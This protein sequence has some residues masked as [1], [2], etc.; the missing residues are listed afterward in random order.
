MDSRRTLPVALAVVLLAALGAPAA[1]AAPATIEGKLSKRGFTVM[2][3][4]ARGR[5][6]T[7]TGARAFRVV[8][9][10]RAVT[11]HLRDK[12]GRYAGP[13]VVGVD[14]KQVVVGVRAGTKL[15]RVRVRRGYATARARP[16]DRVA[17]LKARARR[18]RPIGAGLLGRVRAAASGKDGAGRDPDRDGLPGAFDVDDDGDLVLDN[19]DRTPLGARTSVGGYGQFTATV[20]STQYNAQWAINGGLEVSYLADARG[21]TEGASGYAVNQNAAGPFA[22]DA[23]FAKLR[24]LFMIE[25]GALFLPLSEA[26]TELDCRGLSYCSSGG[27]GFFHTRNQPFPGA[28]DEDGDGAGTM[29]AVPA[30]KEG[31][32]GL[33]VIQT[34]DP[35]TVFGLAPLAKATAIRAGDLLIERV[36]PEGAQE[37]R[38]VTLRSVFGTVPALAAWGD[39]T[40]DVTI[41]Y[42]VPRGAEGAENNGFT[43]RPNADGEHVVRLT[44]WR[45]Q[46]S[47]ISATEPSWVDL[48]GLTYTIVGKTAEQNRRLFHCEGSSYSTSDGNLA[49]APGGLLDRATD[50]PVNRANTLTF[51]VNLTKCLRASGITEQ[52]PPTITVFVAA[53]SG[54]G[55]IA[56]GVGFA[57]KLVGENDAGSDAFSGTWKFVG[58]SPGPEL[59]WTI[60]SNSATATGIGAIVYDGKTVTGGTPPAGWTCQI[61]SGGNPNDTY[62][63]GG[64]TLAPGQSATGRVTV[65]G[66]YAANK[67]V[68]MLVCTS[69]GCAGSGMVYKP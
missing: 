60:T 19:V 62:A 53:S 24:D 13:V 35:K 41:D 56:E 44:V 16:G 65:D 28:F 30:F 29:R 5:G 66:A 48:G 32:D 39:G 34:V 50:Q 69:A 11:L 26:P 61:Q 42:P 10:A 54:Y 58:G 64:S 23:D 15:G 68:D 51:S 9:T 40:R 1:G 14:G 21:F 55:D 18:G 59:E 37:H 12:N 46:R 52:R 36:G 25:R 45:P 67:P 33:G 17:T 47:A 6:Q 27:T 7:A 8:P 49:V 38:Y 31:Q 2:A 4:D 43:V 57:F 3:L 20:V 22:A 63:C